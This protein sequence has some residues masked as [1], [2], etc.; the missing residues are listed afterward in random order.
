[1]FDSWFGARPAGRLA[2]VAAAASHSY[3]PPDSHGG[4]QF[5]ARRGRKQPGGGGWNN[6]GNSSNSGSG[7][8]S[9]SGTNNTFTGSGSLPSTSGPD[10]CRRFNAG[11]CRNNSNNCTTGL[12]GTGAKLLH[13]CSYRK[14][15]GRLCREEHPECRHR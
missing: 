5:Y 1:V 3:R 15:D 10:L 8:S 2:A 6:T 11:T 12:N 7:F 13:R 4:N 14:R 9:G